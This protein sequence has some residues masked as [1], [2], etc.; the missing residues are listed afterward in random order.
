MEEIPA[1]WRAIGVRT[2]IVALGWWVLSEGQTDSW[3]VGAVT[4]VIAVAAS[5]WLAPPRPAVRG[6]LRASVAFGGFFLVQ[7]LRA[8]LQ[9]AALALAPRG[10]LAPG[11]V[12]VTLDLEPGAPR[13]A[14]V[15]ALSLLPG[16]LSVNL[17]GA[18]LVVHALTGV[19]RVEADVRALEARIAPLFGSSS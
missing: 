7:S 10:R 11:S 12:D 1:R 18:Q 6:R 14:L 5:L 19:D 9:V 3:P 13:Y 15:A 17:D 2:A 4:I 8:G 16:T